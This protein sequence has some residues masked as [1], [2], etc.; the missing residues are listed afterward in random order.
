MLISAGITLVGTFSYFLFVLSNLEKY[1]LWT[2]DGIE[3]ELSVKPRQTARLSLY[4]LLV[5][6]Y[7]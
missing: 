4:H 1:V 3:T 5:S 7:Y 6:Y 2:K